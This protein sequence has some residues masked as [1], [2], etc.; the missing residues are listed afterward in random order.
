[1]CIYTRNDVLSSRLK[2]SCIGQP[3]SAAHIILYDQYC[4][5]VLKFST[6]FLRR[7]LVFRSTKVPVLYSVL[8]QVNLSVHVD[9]L[10]RTKFSTALAC[11]VQP[12][13]LGVL[14]PPRP[15]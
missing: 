4:P 3:Y 11:L 2:P 9:L 15:Q 10:I 12:S 1:M 5:A 13:V 7:D 6:A 8:E 14:R